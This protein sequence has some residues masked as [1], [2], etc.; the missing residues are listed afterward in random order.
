MMRKTQSVT[1]ILSLV[2]SLLMVLSVINFPVL[3][4]KAAG[5]VDGFVERCYKQALGRNGEPSG[6]NY[7]VNILNNKER[8]P[9]EVAYGFVFSIECVN[10]NLSNIEFTR[11]LYR[12]YLGREAEAGGA[13]YWAA[14]LNNGQSRTN[15]VNSFASSQE[16]TNIV[17][18]YGLSN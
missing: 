8:T 16:F 18:S 12:L 4:A 1:R 5:G 17:T 6:I 15:L 7:W 9:A 2:M 13:E 3:K 10:K 14:M 11:M